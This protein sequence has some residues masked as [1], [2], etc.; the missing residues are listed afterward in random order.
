[1]HVPSKFSHSL[2]SAPK[3]ALVSVKCAK[4]EKGVEKSLWAP[5]FTPFWAAVGLGPQRA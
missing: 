5:S 4:E 3:K 2:L 1:M